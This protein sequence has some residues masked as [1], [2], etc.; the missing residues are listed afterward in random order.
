MPVN[1]E[2]TLPTATLLQRAEAHF[3]AIAETLTGEYLKTAAEISL[4]GLARFP[5]GLTFLENLSHSDD[6]KDQ[7]LHR[8]VAGIE[9]ENP[10]MVGAGWDKKGRA[11]LGLHALGFSGVEVGTVPL[12]PQPGNP[13][14]RLWTDSTHSVGLNRL[15]FNTPGAEVVDKI[16]ANL[17]ERFEE[18][19]LPMPL[20]INV[21]LNKLAS[22][23][24]A[25][26]LH[27]LAARKLKPHASYIAVGLSSPNTPGLRQLQ[28]RGPLTEIL[29]AVQEV[30]HE[31]EKPLPL[32]VKIAPDNMTELI[33]DI[34]E[35]AAECGAA[36]LIATNT[37]MSEKIKQKYGWEGEAGG[38]SGADGEYQWM[39]AVMVR[40]I[41]DIRKAA[42]KELEI[43]GVGGINSAETAIERLM[44]GASMLQVVTAIRQHKWHTAHHINEGMLSWIHKHGV[45]SLDEIVGAAHR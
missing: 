38:V 36:G 37:T 24:I 8:T 44:A 3:T 9:F 15:G 35:V 1:P 18:R 4:S 11:V 10:L 25:P 43:I 20:G 16:L 19:R 17:E 21:G 33:H 39:A 41:Y 5:G 13:R 28:E 34:V 6:L 31:D 32:F 7:R 2:A 40:L 23:K 45:K 22:H 30:L 12:F 29:T 27:A 26:E 14:P 42:G